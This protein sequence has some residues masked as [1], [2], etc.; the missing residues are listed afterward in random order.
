MGPITAFF[1]RM[2]V[3]LSSVFPRWWHCFF[4]F[5]LF[6][7]TGVVDWIDQFC[8]VL[9]ICHMHL[10]T[11]YI[12]FRLIYIH[13]FGVLGWPDVGAFMRAENC[14]ISILRRHAR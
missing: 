11:L 12:H 2:V 3:Y 1:S 13:I 5:L 7:R 10:P 14:V 9:D 8:P 4:F 6:W